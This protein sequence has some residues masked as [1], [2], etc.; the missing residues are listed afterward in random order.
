MDYWEELYLAINLPHHT[1]EGRF[2]TER[3]CFRGPRGP[4]SSSQM[5]SRPGVE[6]S[7]GGS[8]WTANAHASRLYDAIVLRSTTKDAYVTLAKSRVNSVI[9]Y[10]PSPEGYGLELV[11]SHAVLDYGLHTMEGT[12][13]VSFLFV[14]STIVHQ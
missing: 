2:Q 7:H 14:L 6:H 12:V 4:L 5:Q 8:A 11:A 1:I 10:Q 9:L 3:V 13:D